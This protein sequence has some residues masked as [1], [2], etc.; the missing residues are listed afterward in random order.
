MLAVAL[1]IPL[2]VADHYLKRSQAVADPTEGLAMVER[3]QRFNPLNPT[4]P[5]REA[6]LAIE[7]RDWDRVEQAYDRAIQ[8]NPEHYAPYMFL[9]TFYERRGDFEKALLY[10]QK[11]LALNPQSK[12]LNE[13][14]ERL[15]SQGSR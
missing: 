1:I 8:L 15:D 10:Y 2:Y 13:R 12:D 6:E 9:A 3:A 4:L 5:E 7:T 11:A 14:V